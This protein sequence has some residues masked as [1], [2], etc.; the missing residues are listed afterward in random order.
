LIDRAYPVAKQFAAPWR[1]RAG[2]P[3]FAE[4]SRAAQRID[5]AYR[6]STPWWGQCDLDDAHIF[7]A[8]DRLPLRKREPRGAGPAGD[9]PTA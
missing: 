3:E 9:R 5:V 4:V 1:A 2:D 8:A 7:R 6:K